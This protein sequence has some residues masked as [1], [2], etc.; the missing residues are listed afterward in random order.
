VLSFAAEGFPGPGQPVLYAH[1][2]APHQLDTAQLDTLHGSIL[3]DTEL[4]LRNY[5]NLLDRTED[6]ALPEEQSR[7]LIREIIHE[8]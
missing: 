1:G 6:A 4:Q 2:P 8:L 3:L 7:D 5:R